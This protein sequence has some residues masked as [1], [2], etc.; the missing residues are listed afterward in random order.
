MEYLLDI[1]FEDPHYNAN[2]TLIATFAAKDEE[3]AKLFFNEFVYAFERNNAKFFYTNHYR[4]D[5]D[6]LSFEK[7]YEAYK[8]HLS[9]AT[10]L[11]KVEQFFVEN[12]NQSK[13]L[14]YN[15]MEKYFKNEDSMAKVG[16]ELTLPV[17][18]TDK[19]TGQRIRDEIF[20]YSIEHLM[21]KSL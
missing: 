4:I 18:V 16:R 19:T 12:P 9:K 10:Q 1:R 5:Q 3:D 8:F 11:I 15:L 21:P 14:I 6:E 20:Y 13:S 17:E 7:G 2:V